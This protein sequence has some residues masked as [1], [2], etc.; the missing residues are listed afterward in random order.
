MAVVVEVVTLEVEVFFV[1]EVV[2]VVDNLVTVGSVTT[3][4]VLSD[5]VVEAVVLVVV[6]VFLVFFTTQS[7]LPAW[8]QVISWA[9]YRV[10]SLQVGKYH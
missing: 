7:T 8:S 4:V 3:V 10:P 2:V 5:V 6:D 1:V 9:L